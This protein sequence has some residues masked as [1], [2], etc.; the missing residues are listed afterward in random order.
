MYARQELVPEEPLETR[1]QG[2]SES[3]SPSD[4][5]ETL[6][7]PIPNKGGIAYLGCER[8]AVTIDQDNPD[9]RLLVRVRAFST[10]NLRLDPPRGK[11]VV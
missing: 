3:F 9:K 11:K 2:P 6:L 5:V 1:D 10:R 4:D 8:M 7:L